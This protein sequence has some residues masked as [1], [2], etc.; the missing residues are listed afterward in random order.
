MSERPKRSSEGSE[1]PEETQLNTT[2]DDIPAPFEVI[3]PIPRFEG[4]SSTPETGWM[5]VDLVAASPL[6]G[7]P[8]VRS[9]QARELI[10][11]DIPVR[12]SQLRAQPFFTEVRK[13]LVF[14]ENMGAFESV[15]DDKILNGRAG[16]AEVQDGKV[17]ALMDDATMWHGKQVL[18]CGKALEVFERA[19][20]LGLE[21]MA[22]Y[23]EWYDSSLSQG[24]SLAGE[25]VRQRLHSTRSS[26]KLRKEELNH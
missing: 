25:Q 4:S 11:D 5:V 7:D 9:F 13:L 17:I 14:T 18:D 8:V 24:I 6:G 19:T 10:N 22:F 16:A 3:Y 21:K 26:I 15:W 1:G 2:E 12:L 23:V 20:D